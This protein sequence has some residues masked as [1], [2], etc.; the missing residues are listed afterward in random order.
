[1][2]FSFTQGKLSGAL[3]IDARKSVPVTSV[4][5]RITDL[6][7]EHFIKSNEKPLTG[8]VEARAQLSGSGASVHK[9][10]S[11]ARGIFTAVAPQGGMKKSLAE[12]AGVNVLSALGLS[13]SG[14]QSATNLRCAVMH[15]DARD[16]LLSSQQIVLDT[17][18]TRIDGHGTVN[19][20]DETLNLT[21]QGKPKHFQLL[22]LNAP[23]TLSGKLESPT[24]GVDAKPALTQGAIGL[25]LGLLSP[26]AAIF[27]FVDPGLAKEANCADL[28]ADANSQGASVKTPAKP[29]K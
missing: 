17:D 23:I 2:T 27:A 10:A 6:H 14:D 5:A 20:K 15:F 16:G 3:T 26:F 12:W 28:L 13:L 22:H 24:V 9:V 11:S 4:D 18:P 19:L 8:L 1:L 29:T 21:L 25:G 7:I